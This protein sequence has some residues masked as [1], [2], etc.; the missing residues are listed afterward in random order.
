MSR[1]PRLVMPG[2]PLHIIQRGNNRM[3]CFFKRSDYMVYLAMLAAAAARSECRLHAYVLMSNHIH[4]LATPLGPTSAAAM[5]K[6]VGQDYV[7]YVNRTYSRFG[8]L[9][10]GRYRSCLVQDES[11]FLVCQRYIELNPVRAR[12]VSEPGDYEWSSY[13]ANAEGAKNTVITPHVSYLAISP[14][15]DER[16]AAYKD[17]FNQA[18]SADTMD[19]MRRA[20]NGNRAIGSMAYMDDIGALVCRDIL[21]QQ[22]GRRHY[23]G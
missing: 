13:R 18:I 22:T 8:T 1:H 2:V 6:Q 19:E 15:D 9:W 20:T 7:Q 23:G 12:I 11:Y 16:R 14:F 17:L 3:P 10:Q 4:L 21:P 5:M